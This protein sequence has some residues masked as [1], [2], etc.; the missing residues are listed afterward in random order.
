MTIF[1]GYVA[2]IYKNIIGKR[3]F[4]INVGTYPFDLL[5]GCFDADHRSGTTITT[6]INNIL[7]NP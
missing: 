3:N 2:D 6:S 1:T 7:T 4:D 5:V